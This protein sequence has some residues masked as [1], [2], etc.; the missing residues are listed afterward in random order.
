MTPVKCYRLSFPG[1]HWI[2]TFQFWSRISAIKSHV[3]TAVTRVVVIVLVIFYHWDPFYGQGLTKIPPW[4]SNYIHYIVRDE[5]TYLLPNF[6]GATVEVWEWISNFIP[7]SAWYVITCNRME[8]PWRISVNV[9]L[10]YQATNHNES[11]H[12]QTMCIGCLCYC[13]YCTTRVSL[14]LGWLWSMTALWHKR[15][16]IFP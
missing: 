5:I 9:L 16:G 12:N 14:C 10:E 11:K 4:I 7:H 8:R 6:N 15:G 2:N 13:I 1:N 3:T